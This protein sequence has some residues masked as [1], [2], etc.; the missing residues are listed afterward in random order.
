MCVCVSVWVQGADMFQSKLEALFIQSL[1]DSV[2]AVREAT[3]NNIRVRHTHTHTQTH[4]QTHSVCISLH[5]S[6]CVVQLIA[7]TFEPQ[8]TVEHLLP[9]ILDQ[10]NKATGYTY[11]MATLH[12]IPVGGYSGGLGQLTSPRAQGDRH[13]C[14]CAAIVGRHDARADQPVH[15]TPPQEGAQG[16]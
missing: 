3:I 4:T 14:L 11:R 13:V 12:A 2:F 5:L 16:D 7:E 15:R 1:N 6:V 10:Y 9:K 8:W